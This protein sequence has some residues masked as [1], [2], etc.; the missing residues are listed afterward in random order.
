LA[1]LFLDG[2]PY[3]A[4]TTASDALWAGL[5]LVTCRGNSF[6]G[7]VAASLLETMGLEEMV[8]ENSASFE[9]LA[10]RLSHQPDL[11]SGIRE[12]LAQSFTRARLFDTARATRDVET[13]WRMMFERRNSPPRNFLVPPG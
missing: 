8:A 3:G 9:A 4:H 7:R 5:P 6:A 13:A 12:K 2:L 11:L 10:L 1:D